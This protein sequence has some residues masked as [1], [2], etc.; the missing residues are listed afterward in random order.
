MRHG[1]FIKGKKL[2]VNLGTKL[3]LNGLEKKW[4]KKSK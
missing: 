3:I 4:I 2:S 1:N